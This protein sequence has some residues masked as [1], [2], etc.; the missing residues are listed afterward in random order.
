ME[1]IRACADGGAVDLPK[2]GPN[3]YGKIGKFT[4]SDEESLTLNLREV[5]G[6]TLTHC[7]RRSTSA[8]SI[9]V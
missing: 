2:F 3:P 5:L 7:R 9:L 4:G 1:E 8:V 6:K